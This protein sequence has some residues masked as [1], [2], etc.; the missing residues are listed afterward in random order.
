MR[1]RSRETTTRADR[2]LIR[3]RLDSAPAGRLDANDRVSSFP[4]PVR[5]DGPLD[6]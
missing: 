6:P 4:S 2:G 1:W 3:E 5:P